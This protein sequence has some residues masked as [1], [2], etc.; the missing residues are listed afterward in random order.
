MEDKTTPC[1]KA[2]NQR[3]FVNVTFADAVSSVEEC[4]LLEGQIGGVDV[5]HNSLRFHI[6]PS[7]IKTLRVRLRRDDR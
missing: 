6:R 7:E 2:H 1:S 4:N 3:G 5:D